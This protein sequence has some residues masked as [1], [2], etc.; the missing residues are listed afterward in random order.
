MNT[1]RYVIY[2]S[3]KLIHICCIRRIPLI[4]RF[5]Q[6]HQWVLGAIVGAVRHAVKLRSFLKE[7]PVPIGGV[8]RST[9]E[10]INLAAEELPGNLNG[11][12]GIPWRVYRYNATEPRIEDYSLAAQHIH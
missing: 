8:G 1:L 5:L 6:L 7:A 11:S 3:C 2:C 4:G 12:L 9:I 10:F